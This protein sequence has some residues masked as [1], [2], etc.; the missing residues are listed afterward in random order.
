MEYRAIDMILSILRLSLRYAPT[1][2]VQELT[3]KL[4]G[5]VEADPYMGLL[6]RGFWVPEASVKAVTS[7]HPVVTRARDGVQPV[8]IRVE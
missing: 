6:E 4:Q 5:G 8:K 2:G 1:V 3:V 7:F